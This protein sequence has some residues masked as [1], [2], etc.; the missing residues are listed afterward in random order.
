MLIV[1]DE[2]DQRYRADDRLQP[3]EIHCA[4][5]HVSP[6]ADEMCGSSASIY[7][8]RHFFL[9]LASPN[10][11]STKFVPLRTPAAL[12]VQMERIP[13]MMGRHV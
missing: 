2:I 13:T 10:L 11:S 7:S 8:L 12:T 6:G 9:L 3:D 1:M 5:H 4:C